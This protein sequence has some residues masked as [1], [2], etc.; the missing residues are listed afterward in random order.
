MKRRKEREEI[1][2]GESENDHNSKRVMVAVS[3]SEGSLEKKRFSE[4]RNRIGAMNFQKAG[5]L[6][7]EL[8]G[9]KHHFILPHHLLRR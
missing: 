2:G 6:V 9:N 5:I 8:N 1:Q 4:K 3:Q 7:L